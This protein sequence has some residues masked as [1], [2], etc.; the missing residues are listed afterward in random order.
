MAENNNTKSEYTQRVEE[1]TKKLMHNAEAQKEMSEVGLIVI[2]VN[3]EPGA[4]HD[5]VVLSMVGR[6]RACKL[7][8]RLFAN[9]DKDMAAVFAEV[10]SEEARRRMLKCLGEALSAAAGDEPAGEDE[11]DTKPEE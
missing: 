3:T 9:K 8:L 11:T 7:G 2:S 10:V 1:L 6:K 4:G 5:E